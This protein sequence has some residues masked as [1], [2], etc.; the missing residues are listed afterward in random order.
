MK[1]LLLSLLFI[2]ISLSF[3]S[4]SNDI[5]PEEPAETETI[6]TQNQEPERAYIVFNFSN[7]F[8][9]SINSNETSRSI[10]STFTPALFSN[11]VFSGSDGAG[12]TISETASSFTELSGRR[13]YVDVGS[14]SFNL[15]ADYGSGSNVEKYKA[16]ANSVSIQPGP[17]AVRMKLTADT[18][19]S[20]SGEPY[21]AADHPGSYLITVQFPADDVDVVRFEIRNTSNTV[22]DYAEKIKSTDY[23]GTGTKTVTFSSN[24]YTPGVYIINV[25]FKKL[26]RE[27]PS[28]TNQ[29]EVISTWGEVLTI[30]PG[31]QSTGTIT[32]PETQQVYTITYNLGEDA[33]WDP[34]YD[35]S[36]FVSYTTKGGDYNSDGTRK[37]YITLPPADAV[38]KDGYIFDGWF[39]NAACTPDAHVTTFNISDKQNKTFYA[40]WHEAIFDVYISCDGSDDN[41]VDDATSYGDGT[42][43]HPFKTISRSYS[44]FEDVTL[45]RVDGSPASTVHILTDYTGADAFTY[46]QGTTIADAKLRIIGAKG[47]T[48]GNAV[49]ITANLPGVTNPECFIYLQQNQQFEVSYVNLTTDKHLSDTQDYCGYGAYNCSTGTTLKLTNCSIQ[50]YY[51]QGTMLN[52]SGTVWLDNVEIKDNYAVSDPTKYDIN[53]YWGCGVA[54][55]DGTLHIKNKVVVKN[56]TTLK[57]DT[58]DL[59]CPWNIWIGNGTIC[60]P[61]EI[62]GAITGSDIGVKLDKDIRTFTHNYASKIGTTDPIT[63]FSSDAGF[64]IDKDDDGEAAVICN[65]YVNATGSSDTDPSYNG[66]QAKPYASISKAVEKITAINSDTLDA[67]IYVTGTIKSNTILADSG[68][69]TLTALTLVI[70]GTGTGSTWQEAAAGAVLTGDIDNN[71]TGDDTILKISTSVDVTLKNLTLTKGKTP[72]GASYDGGA[73]YYAGDGVLNIDSCIINNNEANTKGG[74]IYVSGSNTYLAITNSE[75][76]E[77]KVVGVSGSNGIGCGGAVYVDKGIMG[78]DDTVTLES[79]FSSHY[80]GAVYITGDDSYSGMLDMSGGT[81]KRNGA[82]TQGGGVYVAAYGEFIMSG[83]SCLITENATLQNTNQNEAANSAHGGAVYV[84]KNGTFTMD[85]GTISNNSALSGGA[86]YLKGTFNLRHGNIT[87]NK[88][89]ND[90]TTGRLTAPSQISSNTITQLKNSLSTVNTSTNAS[91]IEVG[92]DG[93]FNMEGGTITSTYSSGQNGAAVCVFASAETNIN[94]PAGTATFNMSGGEITGITGGD[95]EG[96]VYLQA[97]NATYYHLIFNMSGGSI[98]GNTSKYGGGVYLGRCGEFH[99]SGGEISTNHASDSTGAGGVYIYGSGDTDNISLGKSSSTSTVLI[100]DNTRGSSNAVSNLKLN[101][102]N[103]IAVNGQLNTTSEVGITKDFSTDPFTSDFATYNPTISPSQIFTSDNGHI[104]TPET[105]VEG[106]FAHAIE[107]I[108]FGHPNTYMCNYTYNSSTRAVTITIKDSSGNTVPSSLI[109]SFKVTLYITGDPI[110][111]W[112]SQSFTYPAELADLPPTDTSFYVEVTIKPTSGANEAYAYDMYAVTP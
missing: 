59:H 11:V 50:G 68:V 9:N 60:N 79:N 29:Y 14:W 102:Y 66:S 31:V 85:N 56:N 74:A 54:V 51:A 49:T 12:H 110:T 25:S 101:S 24:S 91:N 96:T 26:N 18:S 27:N 44:A 33:A 3:F 84:A 104:I 89:R 100:K 103:V 57:N 8:T 16:T 58:T 105:N 78:M 55:P 97:R 67:K 53:D 82:Y 80:G 1:K 61:I 2:S 72:N 30:N 73:I 35:G 75:I 13:I 90:S 52:V 76:K 77:N 28:S 63:Y 109:N 38:L 93:E 42:R 108:I 23:S 34:S 94:D 41:Y 15:S 6:Q 40:K 106:M 83:T 32:L 65:V 62:D 37:S 48:D 19:A 92:I 46:G 43:D 98:T 81:I 10:A 111:D 17:N 107:N 39:T 86:V 4:C 99:M 20:E 71:G 21:N 5:Q 87:S 95:C 45:S 36:I 69:G 64:D 112:T 88:S 47:G 22:L 7:R 70:E